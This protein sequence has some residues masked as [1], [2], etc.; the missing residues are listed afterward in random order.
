LYSSYANRYLVSLRNCSSFHFQ[1]I[2]VHVVPDFW[3]RFGGCGEERR[4]I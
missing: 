2:H 3:S 1:V 4:R